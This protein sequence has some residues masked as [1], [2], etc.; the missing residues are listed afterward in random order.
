MFIGPVGGFCYFYFKCAVHGPSA[1]NSLQYCLGALLWD[2]VTALIMIT[3]RPYA[4]NVLHLPYYI[5]FVTS[6]YSY[7]CYLAFNLDLFVFLN[8]IKLLI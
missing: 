4:G 3:Q 8:M 5:T 6:F 7:Y 2:Y 1:G